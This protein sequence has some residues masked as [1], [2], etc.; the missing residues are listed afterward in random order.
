MVPSHAKGSFCEL[1][2]RSSMPVALAPAV[3]THIGL[4]QPIVHLPVVAEVAE[5]T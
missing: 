5:E 2:D 1:I 3:K 4:S